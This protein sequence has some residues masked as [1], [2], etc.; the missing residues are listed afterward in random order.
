MHTV[1]PLIDET[2]K[3]VNADTLREK[4]NLKQIIKTIIRIEVITAGIIVILGILLAVFI[5]RSVISG[6]ASIVAMAKDIS[7]GEGDL[8]ARLDDSA[9]DELGDLARYFNNFIAQIEGIIREIKINADALATASEELTSVSSGLNE[10]AGDM[11]NKSGSVAS[12]TEQMSSNINNIASASEEMAINI[13]SV[14]TVAEQMSSNMNTVASTVEEFTMSINNIAENSKEALDIASE[15]AKMSASA[16][17][18]MDT[19]GI[20][21]GEIGNVTDVIKRIAEQTNLLALNA[22][23]EAASAGDAGKGFAVVA[24]EIKEL[25]NQSATAAEDIAS[26]IGGIQGSVK[27]AVSVIDQ[28][29]TVIKK[30]GGSVQVIDGAVE[31]QNKAAQDISIN[32]DQ[33]RQGA[34]NIAGSIG[35]VAKGSSE[36]SSNANDAAKGAKNVAENIGEVNYAVD[37]SQSGVSQVSSSA[38][39]LSKVA[40][41]I[42]EMVAEFKVAS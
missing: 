18:T 1:E 17:A 36:M 11:K 16:N 6:I 13:N 21:A 3:M 22:T 12:A 41:E 2:I 31:Q 33:A 35:E 42:K 19:L 8:T 29:S 26:R 37:Q 5:T 40:L 27:S 39:E 20:A 14:S 32:V 30:I 23:I 38:K 9:K 24:N 15:A 7:E 28:V 4:Q 34:G 10:Q 25:A